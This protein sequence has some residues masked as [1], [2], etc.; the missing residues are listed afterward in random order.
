[1]TFPPLRSAVGTAFFGS[2]SASLFTS[3]L[4]WACACAFLSRGL[5]CYC[6]RGHCGSNCLEIV[7]MSPQRPGLWLTLYYCFLTLYLYFENG[8]VVWHFFVRSGQSRW[9]YAKALVCLYK[10]K[11]S[12][13]ITLWRVEKWRAI[14]KK[15]QW[16][17]HRLNHL[18][19]WCCHFPL[20]RYSSF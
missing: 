20:K 18:H 12:T 7:A 3:K 17:S 14:H 6:V 9:T 13:V 2:C 10:P 4:G 19:R 1:M 15:E 16:L 8:V 5:E 11:L